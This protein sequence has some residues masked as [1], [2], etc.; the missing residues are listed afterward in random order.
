[1]ITLGES[2]RVAD[3]PD[4]LVSADGPTPS[5][6]PPVPTPTPPA[7][8]EIRN[9]A[10]TGAGDGG[11]LLSWDPVSGKAALVLRRI[12]ALGVRSERLPAASALHFDQ[13]T[14]S[15]IVGCYT[16]DAEGPTGAVVAR[17]EFLCGV[18]RFG[19]P[20]GPT[21][22]TI[23]FGGTTAVLAWQPEEGAAGYVVVPLGVGRAPIPTTSTSATDDTGGLFTC[24]I[25][26]ALPSTRYSDIVCGRS[27]PATSA[28]S[29]ATPGASIRL[30]DARRVRRAGPAHARLRRP[31]RP[32][33]R[34]GA[35]PDHAGTG[36]PVRSPAGQDSR[37]ERAGLLRGVIACA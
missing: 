20:G 16:L 32:L 18:P 15:E 13:V 26:V 28:S 9:F 23:R 17:S 27:A 5:P 30:A 14:E 35:D 7:P 22:L 3:A 4:V 29:V 33:G 24:Y 19:T 2:V 1:M 11:M 6:T 10:L 34:A 37:R 25:V 36:G 31:Q 21:L 12:T 8:T